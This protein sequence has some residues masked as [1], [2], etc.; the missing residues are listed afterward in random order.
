MPVLLASAKEQRD[1]W[2]FIQ[3][4]ALGD[5]LYKLYPSKSYIKA[6]TLADDGIWR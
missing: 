5:Y 6:L 3:D 2:E 1:L 4:T